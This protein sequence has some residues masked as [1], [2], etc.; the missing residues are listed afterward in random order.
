VVTKAWGTSRVLVQNE[1]QK[2]L[3][4]SSGLFMIAA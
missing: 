3:L 2:R 4:R 1:T